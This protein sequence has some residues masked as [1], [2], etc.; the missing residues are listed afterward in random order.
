MSYIQTSYKGITKRQ[1]KNKEWV[2]YGAFWYKFEQTSKRVKIGGKA[3]GITNAKKAYDELQKIANRANDRQHLYIKKEKNE[4]V[5]HIGKITLKFLADSYF[6]KRYIEVKQKYIR[7]FGENISID[8]EDDSVLKAKIQAVSGEVNRFTNHIANKNIDTNDN[9]KISIADVPV[10]KITYDIID[11]YLVSLDEKKLAP[12]TYSLI[13]NLLKTIWNYGLKSDIITLKNPF[14]NPDKYKSIYSNPKTTR[15]RILNEEE[16]EAL[17][18]ALKE[19]KNYNAYYCAY[20]ALTTGARATT[21]LNIKKRDINLDSLEIRLFNY[22]ASSKYTVP[23]SKKSIPFYETMFKEHNF[24][25]DDYIIQPLRKILYKNN[26]MTEVPRV[27]YDV[28]NEL[29]NDKSK[30]KDTYYRNNSVVNFH[31]LRHTFASRLVNSNLPLYFVK[32]FLNHADIST[33][34]RYVKEDKNKMRSHLDNII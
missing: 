25:E 9:R 16:S 3:D 23:I 27:F 22:K 5:K 26:S 32:E 7:K 18:S 30:M 11:S 17:L 28:C 8:I 12:K 15:E 4:K 2:F 31:T 1:L 19:H 10:S 21:V 20:I 14:S 13:F 29:F 33:T 24:K 6:E 34:M